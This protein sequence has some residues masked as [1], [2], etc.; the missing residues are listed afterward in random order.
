M[1]HLTLRPHPDAD[2]L[3]LEV[4]HDGHAAP[5]LSGTVNTNYEP[6]STDVTLTSPSGAALVL[7]SSDD[8][9]GDPRDGLVDALTQV[10]S[11]LR[12]SLDVLE[13]NLRRLPESELRHL[14]ECLTR[15]R[16]PPGAFSGPAGT[17]THVRPK[18]VE[19]G[20]NGP[21][22]TDLDDDPTQRVLTIGDGDAQYSFTAGER[23]LTF[24]RD[25]ATRP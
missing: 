19:L 16:R 13:R 20:S 24:L 8:H 25:P 6:N 12:G 5:I 1:P 18:H 23:T 4:Y 3:H 7:L 22:D 11:S 2:R 14:T 15:L 9:N 10:L 17:L 21:D